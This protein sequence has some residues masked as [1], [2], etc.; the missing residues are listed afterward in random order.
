MKTRYNLKKEFIKRMNEGYNSS[1]SYAI[2]Y[3]EFAKDN[4]YDSANEIFEEFM[5]EV[6]FKRTRPLSTVTSG[7]F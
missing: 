3:K 7:K 1:D 5:Q 2:M 4:D 6:S